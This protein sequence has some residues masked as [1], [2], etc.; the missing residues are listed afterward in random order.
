LRNAAARAWKNAKRASLKPQLRV[1]E[2]LFEA[3]K[4][5]PAA[6]L[7]DDDA[8]QP[9]RYTYRCYRSPQTTE[10]YIKRLLATGSAVAPNS[11]KIGA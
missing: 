7:N 4:L 6:D 1:L 2:S 9:P 5:M 8:Q 11:V 10:I 3:A